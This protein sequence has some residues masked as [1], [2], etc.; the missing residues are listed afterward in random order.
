M[1]KDELLKL[2]ER[3]EQAEGPDRDV[4]LSIMRWVKNI[5]G[6]SENAARYT[7]S[8]D[9]ALTLTDGSFEAVD[10]VLREATSA[11]GER[12]HLH[13]MPWPESEDY[14]AKLRLFVCAAALRALAA[15]GDG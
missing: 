6:P 1:N 10:H 3:C 2:A 12:Y 9:A 4:D 14:L 15:K 11:L 8:L 13:I 7:A 5:G